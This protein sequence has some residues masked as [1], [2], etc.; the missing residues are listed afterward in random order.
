[1]E[2]TDGVKKASKIALV[3][4]DLV[5]MNKPKRMPHQLIL[6]KLLKLKKVPKKLLLLLRKPLKNPKN[7]KTPP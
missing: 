5:V 1:M 4:T 6:K 2:T 7:P 3:T